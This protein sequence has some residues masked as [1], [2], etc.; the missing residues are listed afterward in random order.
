M[1][2]PYGKC[3]FCFEEIANVF[4]RVAIVLPAIYE[5]PSFS[6][7]SSAFGMITIVYFSCS[8]WCVV[9]KICLLIRGF[10]PFTPNVIIISL[11]LVLPF[12]S[13]R[14]FYLY[15][16]SFVLFLPSFKLTEHM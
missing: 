3:M 8:N 5:R 11:D 14:F 15:Y 7:S 1:D 9:V 4:S 12:C 13:L 10:G 2:A 6:S 16:Y